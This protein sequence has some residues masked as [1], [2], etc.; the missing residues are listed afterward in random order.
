MKDKKKRCNINDDTS[1][2][3]ARVIMIVRLNL[4][5]LARIIV[6]I[7]DKETYYVE[8]LL[9]AHPL[10]S[11]QISCQLYLIRFGQFTFEK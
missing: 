1:I 2:F 4:F 6:S 11:P 7:L 9:K 3:I 10:I 5:Q 8:G